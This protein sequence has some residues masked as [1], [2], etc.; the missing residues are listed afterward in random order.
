MHTYQE[1]SNRKWVLPGDKILTCLGVR[2]KSGSETLLLGM[3]ILLPS[4]V[5]SLMGSMDAE[6]INDDIAIV[7]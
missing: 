5:H 2:P 3:V 4:A 6:G 7:D 1:T